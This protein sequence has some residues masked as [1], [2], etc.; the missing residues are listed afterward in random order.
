MP[1]PS[2]S[3]PVAFSAD[4]P[5][6]VDV[7]VIGA[8]VI[9]VSTAYYLA[10][11]GNAVLLCE[12][13]RVAGEQSSR[14]WGWVRQQGRDPAELPIMMESIRLWDGLADET[15]EDLGFSRDG[16]VY[17]AASDKELADYERWLHD[18]AKPHQLDTRLL[19]AA[20]TAEMIPDLADHWKGALYTPSDGRAE[21]FVAVPALARAADR[22]GA[23][24]IEDCAVRTIDTS[25]GRVIGVMTEHG[26]VS[27]DQVVLAGGA[28]S[29]AFLLN[30][31]IDLPQLAVK[32]TVARTE[33][34]TTAFNGNVAS[35]SFAYRKRADGG[36]SIALAE[37]HE[38]FVSRASFRHLKTF[39][40][41]LKTSWR[42]TDIK[43]FGDPMATP[44]GE[45]WRADQ[46][47]PFEHI[48]VLDPKP[49][50]GLET[51]LRN[52][53][54][55]TLPSLKA[56]ELIEAWS[57]MIDTTPDV[58]PVIDQ[59]PG[60]KGFRVATGFSGHG[61]GIGPGAG[62][63]I[64]D[65]VQGRSPGHDLSRFRFSRFTDGTKLEP[66]PTI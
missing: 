51:R 55:K 47:S 25:D 12:K 44:S 53:L 52:G 17:L 5:I 48:R 28:W 37:Y 33:A 2:A 62:R 40:P 15:G 14:N 60:I 22:A 38:H 18:T 41:L 6:K 24:I 1:P 3:T 19:S 29:S 49:S 34:A 23:T 26:P 45:H 8:G 58:V 11:A 61:F 46:I 65:L 64:A 56:T 4:L 27:C 20:E 13:G 42:D 66:G 43:L 21:P 54:H 31:G 59:L 32:A 16:V 10:K 30:L 50:P 9:G 39:W 63:V 57:G 7:V 35:Q 36:Y